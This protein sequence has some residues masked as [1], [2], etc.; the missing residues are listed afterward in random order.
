MSTKPSALLTA[1]IKLPPGT[2]P[3]DV[4]DPFLFTVHHKDDFPKGNENFGPADKDFRRGRHMG[5]DFGAKDGWN[6]YHGEEVPGFPQHPHRGFETITIVTNGYIDHS[7]SL[8]A[9][10]RFGMGD[11]QWLTAGRGI[12]HCEMFPLLNKDKRNPTELFQIWLNLPKSDKMVDPYFSML[13]AEDIPKVKV[14]AESGSE[15]TSKRP[16]ALITVVGG[17]L[18]ICGAPASDKPFAV[19]KPP[20]NSFA[21]RPHSNF[22]VWVIEIQ[23]GANVTIPPVANP[24][25]FPNKSGKPVINRNLFFYQGASLTLS[26]TEDEKRSLTVTPKVRI[27]LSYEHAVVLSNTDTK[28]TAHVLMLQASPI[29]EPVVQH[30]P[31][32]MNTRDEINQTFMEYRRTQFGGWKWNSDE[33]THGGLD[34]GRFAR[35][36]DGKVEKRGWSGKVKGA[37]GQGSE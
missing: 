20:P 16:Y 8:G 25:Q 33:P 21:A 29:G 36:V 12:V 7:D 27:P 4:Q 24:V 35:H 23:P 9:A 18:P 5:A 17:N 31:F 1:P 13:W 11:T 28:E 19:P 6:M 14:Y 2:T 32:V 22:A 15:D 26:D 10:A 34:V 3:W 37:W 30:G